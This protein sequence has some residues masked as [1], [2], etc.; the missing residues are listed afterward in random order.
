M[1]LIACSAAAGDWIFAYLHNPPQVILLLKSSD[2]IMHDLEQLAQL[3]QQ[4]HSEQLSSAAA[5]QQVACD[6]AE[7]PVAAAAAQTEQQQLMMMMMPQLVLRQWH[8]L[9]PDREYRCFVH[10]HK[11]VAISQRDVSQC[12]PQLMAPGEVHRIREQI[13]EFH[14]RNIKNSFPSPSCES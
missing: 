7:G 3:Q 5:Q 1:L 2:R 8:D 4:Q 11:P 9:P 6:A 14:A 12:F 10:Q 13:L